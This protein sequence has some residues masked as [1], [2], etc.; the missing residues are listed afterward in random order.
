MTSIA[1][2]AALCSSIRLETS[3]S[4]TALLSC[5]IF[6]TLLFAGAT[7]QSEEPLK[8][9]HIGGVFP[10][11]EGAG[12]WAGGQ[13]CLPAVK[14]ALEDINRQ[15]QILPGYVLKLHWYNS[16]VS[17]RVIYKNRALWP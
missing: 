9:L 1:A 13:A 15:Q 11:E 17:V 6:S 14:M 7:G 12:G 8:E 16:K 3:S 2:V 10:M 4:R 5:L